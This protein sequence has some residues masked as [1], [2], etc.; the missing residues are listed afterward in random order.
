MNAIIEVVK[1]NSYPKPDY[2]DKSTGEVDTLHNKRHTFTSM[3]LNNGIDPMWVS[4]TLGHEN[5][6][7]TLR[8]YAYFMP[9]KEKMV[10]EFLDK[11]YKNGT[12]SL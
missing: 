5:L 11:R 2:K 6:D 8:V 10:I 4:N 12:S 7:I 9:R 1:T 3:M